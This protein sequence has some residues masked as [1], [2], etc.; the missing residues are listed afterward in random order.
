MRVYKLFKQG[1]RWRP[2]L[3][4]AA[5]PTLGRGDVLVRIETASLNYRDLLVV[6]RTP[7]PLRMSIS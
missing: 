3:S 7:M 4:E 6:G 1:E 5:T 2:T